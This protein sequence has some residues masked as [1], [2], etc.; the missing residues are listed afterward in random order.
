MAVGDLYLLTVQIRT[1]GNVTQIGLGFEQ[2][3]GTNGPYTLEATTTAWELSVLPTLLLALATDAS[4]ERIA[5]VPV[6]ATDEVPGQTDYYAKDGVVIGD[7]LPSNMAAVIHMATTG[8]NA[9]HNGRV[10]IAGISELEQNAG[11]LTVAQQTLMDNIAT[12]L[13]LDVAPTAPEDANFTPVVISRY[14]DGV[15]R[16]PPIGY[17][18]TIP[19]A[20]N[21]MRQQ[22]RRKTPSFGFVG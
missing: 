12:K 11:R 7:G 4:V 2:D 13:A 18:V 19:V 14:V 8:P 1:G 10:Y 3:A 5:M 21:I 17:P 20:R 6:T 16:T 22:R 9:K 15:K